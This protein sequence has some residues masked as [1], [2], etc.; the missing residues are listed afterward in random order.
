MQKKRTHSL[1]AILAE[2]GF[3]EGDSLVVAVSGGPDSMALLHQLR[4]FVR[5]EALHVA[6]LDHAIRAESLNDAQYVA[7]IAAQWNLPFH[8]RRVDVPA[9]AGRQGW[10]LEEAGRQARYE[11]FADLALAAGA[12]CVAVGHNAD[13]QAETVLLHCL[14]GSGLT[15]LRGMLPVSPLLGDNDLKLIRPL[16]FQTRAEIEAY[17]DRFG[18]NPLLD[19]TNRDPTYA[20]N[21]IRHQLLP[22]LMTYNPQIKSHLA[23]LAAIAAAEEA[24]V[25]DLVDAVWP[26]L[27]VELGPGWL[28]LDRGRFQEL[29]L[30]IQRRTLRR[31]TETMNPDVIDLSFKTV[32]QALEAA[33]RRESG[34]EAGLP[35][36]LTMLAD[37]EHLIFSWASAEAPTDLPQ[38]VTDEVVLLPVPGQIRLANGWL[39][40]AR[41]LADLPDDLNPGQ[42]PWVAT[43]NLQEGESLFLR[44]R[45][46]GERMQPLGMDG[47]SS[48]VQDIMVNRKLAA[49][50][51]DRWPVLAAEDHLAWIV[52][53]TI[54][55]RCRVQA[56]SSG[57]VR[58]HCRRIDE[59]S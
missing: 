30:A 4:P 16:L 39:L 25:S 34:I 32:E 51:R 48:S 36:G 40:T 28:V 2:A 19:E 22:E 56:D 20:R 49:R 24:L 17:C 31:A 45:Q 54:D 29:P 15:G 50:L 44:T 11:F 58:V 10:S 14:R 42:D 5:P 53:H 18:L 52:G 47:H 6:H 9:L 55:H 27:L 26:E 3:T 33:G 12:A 43:I 8:S 7:A 59:E 1:R 21:R 46:P 23:Q 38:V 35:G 57:I 13:D 41:P 37:Y